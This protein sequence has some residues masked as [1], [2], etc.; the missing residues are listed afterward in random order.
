MAVTIASVLASAIDP[1]KIV[2][3][4][5]LGFALRRSYIW[6]AIAL[7]IALVAYIYI[8]I[9]SSHHPG[10]QMVVHL[11]SSIALLGLAVLILRI[12]GNKVGTAIGVAMCAASAGAVWLAVSASAQSEL[13]Y[14]GHQLSHAKAAQ[15]SDTDSKPVHRYVPPET[16][17]TD[18]SKP[19]LRWLSMQSAEY[20]AAVLRGELPEDEIEQRKVGLLILGLRQYFRED[21]EI[22]AFLLSPGSLPLLVELRSLLHSQLLHIYDADGVQMLMYSSEV[23]ISSKVQSILK[24]MQAQAD[25]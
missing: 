21:A 9:G 20:Q 13:S 23:R 5:G 14:T 2:L 25:L 19:E 3:S 7:G 22:A 18:P 10:A 1:V 17:D 11:L 4:F 6:L 8:G 12:A 24:A 16:K 15:L